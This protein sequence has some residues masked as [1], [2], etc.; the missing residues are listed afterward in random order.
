M[1]HDDKSSGIKT[2][3]HPFESVDKLQNWVTTKLAQ[4]WHFFLKK[5]IPKQ[6]MKT[7]NT[8]KNPA[9]KHLSEMFSTIIHLGF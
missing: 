4:N 9:E 5:Q 2:P 8:G 6:W 7:I 3:P 1:K